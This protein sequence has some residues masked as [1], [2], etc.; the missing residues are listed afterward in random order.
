MSRIHIILLF[1]LFA[2]GSFSQNE[3]K[4]LLEAGD[5]NFAIGDYH[6]ATIFYERA[7]AIDSGTVEIIWKTA[8]ASRMYRDYRKAKRLYTKVYEKEEGFIYS[9]S[10][11]YRGLMEKQCG[12]YEIALATF[13]Q[14]KKKYKSDKDSYAYLK[15]K[16]EVSSC[17]WAMNQ[18]QKSDFD[19]ISFADGI[20][21]KDAEFGHSITDKKIIFSS[22]KADSI[23]SNEEVYDSTYFTQLFWA[24]LDDGSE[25]EELKALNAK[26]HHTGNGSFSLDMKRFYFSSCGETA[27]SYSCKIK[28]AEYA[29]GKWRNVDE[30]GEVI[31]RP[32][33]SQTMP[34]IAQ[35]DGKEVLLFSS[36]SPSGEGQYDIFISEIKNGNIYTPPQQFPKINSFENELSPFWDDEEQRLYFSSN[37]GDGFGGYDIFYSERIDGAFQ[38]KVNAGRPL[39]SPANDLYYFRQDSLLIL[40]TNRVGVEHSKNLTCCTDIIA[41]KKKPEPIFPP[42]PKETLEEL[43]RRL[44]ITMYFHNDEPNPR[45]R[46]TLTKINYLDSYSAFREMLRK[47]Q[48]EYSKGLKGDKAEEAQEDI[49]RFF[50]EHVDQGV[51]DLEQFRDLLLEELEKGRKIQLTI[52]GFASPLAESDYNVNLTKRRISS[53]VNYLNDYQNGVF[54]KFIGDSSENSGG[55]TF[56]YIPFGE[57]T[58]NNLVSDNLNDQKNSVYSRAAAMERKIEIQSISFMKYSVEDL[59]PQVES[60]VQDLGLIS[61]KEIQRL[62]FEIKN[63]NRTSITFEEPRI[64]CVCSH[65]EI[66]K[67]TLEPGET[68]KVTFEFDPSSYTGQKFVKSIY[69]KSLEN[70]EEVRLVITGTVRD[71]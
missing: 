18:I 67:K 42:S 11:L 44:P 62:T 7:L 66:E 59:P 64:P 2:S 37:S 26:G 24:N 1:L 45:S 31:N 70:A 23:S 35:M 30:L 56:A 51:K 53:L 68:T 48:N 32:G 3:I 19:S 8:E 40:S 9:M 28:V 54:R 34:R 47:Y 65:A 57:Y 33:E 50:I 41:F 15:S 22:M 29:E 13:K 6:S 21:T 61:S 25:L 69:I 46:D 27:G 60:P 49:E 16:E 39:N 36:N 20:N 52:K 17:V 10:L 43:N 55:L 5:E 71:D 4:K 38:E 58:A 12:E 14:A 63:T